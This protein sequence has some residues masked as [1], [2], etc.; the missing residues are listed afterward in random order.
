VK[1][2]GR[3]AVLAIFGAGLF[4]LVQSASNASD[5]GECAT[6]V[7]TPDNLD[8]SETRAHGHY[9]FENGTLMVWTEGSTSLDK[10]AAYLAVDI[11]FADF[12]GASMDYTALFGIPP[13]LQVVVDFD[14]NGTTDGILVGEAVYGDNWWLTNSAATFVKDRAP[15]FGGGNGS[16]WFG[17]LEE[18][19]TAFPDG[20]VTAVGFSLGSG[21]YASGVI[22]SLTFDCR[23]W[24]F[25]KNFGQWVRTEA[26]GGGADGKAI[27]GAA[28]GK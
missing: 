21:V 27:S 22:N 19:K 7:V 4:G 11:P 20:R 24:Y 17:T 25:A 2:I 16:N 13:G 18:W 28:K 14:G 26:K 5:G 6:Q 8:F 1:V 10:V 23:T 15:H 9:Q 3:L 12:D